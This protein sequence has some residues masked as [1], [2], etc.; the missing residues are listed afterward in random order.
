MQVI[1]DEICYKWDNY[2]NVMQI[3]RDRTRLHQMV[4]N[5]RCHM[6]T[7]FWECVIACTVIEQVADSQHVQSAL[8]VA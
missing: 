2:D 3:F 7:E 5:H 1:D 4:Y 6:S 8:F